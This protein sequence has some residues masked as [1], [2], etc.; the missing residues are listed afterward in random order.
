M[1]QAEI[2][3][4]IPAVRVAINSRYR[5]FRNPEGPQGRID[6][7]RKTVTS[8]V[9]EERIELNYQ[10]ADEARGYAER[11]INIFFYGIMLK[12]YVFR[13]CSSYLSHSIGLAIL[14]L[15][16]IFY[17]TSNMTYTI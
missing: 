17:K 7:L 10:R 11:V 2:R 9:K 1:N 4:L 15:L 12:N 8:L 3:K 5:R 14:N 6:I 16:V 13:L